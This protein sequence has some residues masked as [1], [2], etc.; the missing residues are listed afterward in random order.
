[1]KLYNEQALKESREANCGREYRQCSISVMDTIADPDITFDEHGVSNYYNIFQQHDKLYNVEPELRKQ[2]LQRLV[3]EIKS[4]SGKGSKYDCVLGISGGVDS[5]YLALFAKQHGLNP[6]LVHFD[7]GWNSEIA[8]SNIEN[9]SKYTGFDLYTYVIDWEQFK[10]LQRSYFKASVL[11]L[12][13][14]ADHLI[15]GALHDVTKKFRIK[16]ILNGSNYVTEC[17][18]PPTWN[19]SK[20]DLVNLKDIH[21]SFSKMSLNKLPLLGFYE[22]LRYSILHNIKQYSLLNHTP[23]DKF[24]VIDEIKSELHWKDYGGK[25]FESVFTRFYQGYILPVKF[26]VDKR[27]AHLSNLVFAGSIT[28]EKAMEI[29]AQPVYPVALQQEDYEYLAKKLSFEPAEWDRILT[30]PNKK[31]TDY[32]T[33]AHLWKRYHKLLRSTSSFRKIFKKK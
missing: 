19:Y 10:E 15:F 30:Q 17:I 21:Y 6:L 25:H 16:S 5:S 12:D 11:D 3:D 2:N 29:L 9:I 31:H 24:K 14:P 33:D 13:V 18:L 8:V 23:Y 28:K 20:F 4:R 7:Y 1:M 27:K 32:K 26:N 22:S